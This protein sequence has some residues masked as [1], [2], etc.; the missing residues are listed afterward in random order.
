[1][2]DPLLQASHIAFAY[3]R[4]AVLE[5]VDLTVHRRELIGIVGENGC[6]KS[7]LMRVL[8]GRLKPARGTV[9]RP[10]SLGYCPQESLVFDTLTVAENLAWFSAA[11]GLDDWRAAAAPLLE[12][13][14]LQPWL[15][16]AV[17]EVSGGTRQKLNLCIALLH[18]PALLLL[19]EPYAGFD[20]ETWQHFWEHAEALRRD[21][22]GIV[23]V[24]HLLTD[25]E[26]FDRVLS[27]RDGRL[28]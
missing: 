16:T 25:Q 28:T 6:G 20:W 11:Y 9:Q 13:Y 23:V 27:L 4:R 2:T 24:S 15:T 17:A 14:R 10:A 1:V 3:R 8:T 22:K 7:T 12:R 26:R 18:D 5:D 19:D 21:G